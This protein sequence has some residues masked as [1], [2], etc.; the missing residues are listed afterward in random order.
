MPPKKDVGS[1]SKEPFS[2]VNRAETQQPRPAKAEKALWGHNSERKAIPL[3][4]G[5]AQALGEDLPSRFVTAIRGKVGT[6]T[7]L[8]DGMTSKIL[9]GHFTQS[10][11]WQGVREGQITKVCPTKLNHRRP[12]M[13]SASQITG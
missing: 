2:S 6:K 5:K 4:K 8:R 3:G 9:G 10:L 12:A 11:A 13:K 1:W 7:F